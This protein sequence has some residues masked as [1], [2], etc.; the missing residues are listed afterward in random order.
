M[1]RFFYA[2]GVLSVLMG[3]SGCPTA[4]PISD[5]GA[6][7]AAHGEPIAQAPQDDQAAVDALE[8]LAKELKRDGNGNVVE[9]NFRETEIDDS[10][11][12]HLAGL[13]LIKSVLLNKTAVTDTGLET[14]GKIDTLQNIDLR[15][16]AT[17]N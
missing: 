2:V 12:E 1:N 4:G 5:D 3:L 17:A 8:E 11:L 16:C 10:A 14:L 7:P 9:V 15:G 6:E 13:P